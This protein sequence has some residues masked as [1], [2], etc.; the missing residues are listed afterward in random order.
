MTEQV[1][2]VPVADLRPSPSNPRKHGLLDRIDELAA[3]ILSVGLLQPIVV[4]ELETDMFEVVFGHRRREAAIRAGL[5]AVPCLVREYDDGQVLEAQCVENLQRTDV[6]PLDEADGFAV[7]VKRGYTIGG[8]AAKIGRPTAYIAQRLKLCSL[9]KAAQKALDDENVSIGVALELAKLPTHKLQDEALE[10]IAAGGAE[11]FD[12]RG[13]LSVADARKIIE[14]EVMRSLKGA[15]FDPSDAALVPK[16]G[17][18]GICP[19]RTGVQADLFT[20][21]SSPDLCTDPPCFRAKVDAAFAIRSKEHRDAGG[22][23]MSAT[24][25][26]L[27]FGNA[28]NEKSRGVRDEYR[29]LDD[30]D[31]SGPK[32]RTIRQLVGKDA[33]TTLAFDPENGVPVELIARKDVEAAK[34]KA[35]KEDERASPSKNGPSA[36]EKREREAKRREAE[37]RRLV[38]VALVDEATDYFTKLIIGQDMAEILVHAACE[39]A[40]SETLRSV[41]DRRDMPPAPKA[42]GAVWRSPGVDRIRLWTKD[43]TVPVLLALLLE[44]LVSRD[45]RNDGETAHKRALKALGVDPKKVAAEGAAVAAA[46]REKKAAP[47]AKKAKGKRPAKKAKR[48]AKKGAG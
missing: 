48:K 13:I 18:C 15:P 34:R 44:I 21:A 35:S 30:K 32:P 11:R 6:H 12:D 4:R 42:R 25:A 24:N 9:S 36:A 2:S 26:K 33:P 37:T 27:F 29:R 7:L 45:A 47:A 10:M 1:I 3:S 22:E 8:I 19:K 23:V 43:Q 41:A 40:W 20:D 14:G 5:D 46:T 39:S 31:Y 16:A 28:Y 17:P 38:S